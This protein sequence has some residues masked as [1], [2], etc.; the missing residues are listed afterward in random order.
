MRYAVFRHAP[1]V[2]RQFLMATLINPAAASCGIFSA[3]IQLHS[4][5]RSAAAPPSAQLHQDKKLLTIRPPHTISVSL[6]L[7]LRAPVGMESVSETD[8]V[9]VSLRL[10]LRLSRKGEGNR[11]VFLYN[12]PRALYN[13]EVRGQ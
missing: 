4:G 12:C 3:L 5:Q 2:L 1:A 13:P 6:Y 7:R 9:P 11:E 8:H 10:S